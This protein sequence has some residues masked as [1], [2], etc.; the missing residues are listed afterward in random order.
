MLKITDNEVMGLDGL[1][2]LF[3]FYVLVVGQHLDYLK[4]GRLH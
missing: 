3:A 1:S 4:V 2:V